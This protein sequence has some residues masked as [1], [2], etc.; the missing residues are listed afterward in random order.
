MKSNRSNIEKN[1]TNC[2][3]LNDRLLHTT[4]QAFN[5]TSSTGSRLG[6]SVKQTK[7]PKNKNIGKIP[8]NTMLSCFRSNRNVSINKHSGTVKLIATVASSEDV[9]KHPLQ[10]DNVINTYSSQ[11]TQSNTKLFTITIK[12]EITSFL[13]NHRSAKKTIGMLWAIRITPI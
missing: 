12:L 9:R 13:V 11:V 7:I 10:I 1:V 2:T 4:P 8:I 6:K 5:I 3:Y